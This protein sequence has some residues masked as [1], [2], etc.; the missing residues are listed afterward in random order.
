MAKLLLEI[1]HNLSKDIALE[2]IKTILPTLQ[3]Q[4]SD[5]ISELEEKWSGYTNKF[6]FRIKGFKVSGIVTFQDKA[7]LLDGDLPFFAL[8]FKDQ[9]EQ[10]ILAEAN[11][12][13]KW[14]YDGTGN[15]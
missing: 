1:Q 13:L 11:K 7:I 5:L 3:T 9:I 10:T 4:Y 14:N 2:R 12:I 15:S 6:K 8:P